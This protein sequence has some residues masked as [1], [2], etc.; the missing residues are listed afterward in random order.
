MY[1]RS[2]TLGRG[3]AFPVRLDRCGR[4]A[5]S[6]GQ[7][8]IEESIRII[9]G[10]RLGERVMRGGFGSEVPD[11]LFEPATAAT[12]ARLESAIRAALVRWEPRIDVLD[13]EVT[14]DPDEGTRMIA[15]L[16]YRLRDNN[17]LLNQVY[18][19]YLQEGVE[20]R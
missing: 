4:F 15:S 18:P 19:F 13:V 2:K 20:E 11:L 6:D 9:L 1:Q 12:A 5:M 14:C 10:T 16:A 8:R 7:P 3:W 17:A